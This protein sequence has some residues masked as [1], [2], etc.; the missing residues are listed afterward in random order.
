MSLILKASLLQQ[1]RAVRTE[2]DRRLSAP[3]QAIRRDHKGR[4]G[5]ILM[6]WSDP[7]I[8]LAHGR[9]FRSSSAETR[10]DLPAGFDSGVA[11]P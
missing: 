4:I 9:R 8:C 3:A 6:R 7:A 11:L 1:S 2:S 5:S 10:S